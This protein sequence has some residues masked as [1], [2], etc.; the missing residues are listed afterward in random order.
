MPRAW[1]GASLKTVPCNVPSSSAFSAGAVAST[2]TIKGISSFS[3]PAS[4]QASMAPRAMSSLLANTTSMASPSS[5]SH[6]CIRSRA[7]PRC[8]SAAWLD[9]FSIGTPAAVS[10]RTLCSVRSSAS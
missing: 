7:G 4:K 2:P 9:N 5:S 10:V 1:P 3:S 8:Q 6:R